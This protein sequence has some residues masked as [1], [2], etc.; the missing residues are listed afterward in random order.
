MHF[1]NY[2]L[3]VLSKIG[4]FLLISM[5]PRHNHKYS[6][7]PIIAKEWYEVTPIY[8]P[9]L[10]A[11]LKDNV[12]IEELLDPREIANSDDLVIELPISARYKINIFCI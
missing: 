5:I 11:L 3:Q 8:V 12:T 6:Y 7:L 2:S 4:N 10:E 9:V 1:A